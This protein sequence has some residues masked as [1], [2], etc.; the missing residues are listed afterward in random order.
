MNAMI[1]KAIFVL[2]DTIRI[3]HVACAILC[4]ICITQRLLLVSI[5]NSALSVWLTYRL[6]YRLYIYPLLLSPLRKAPG[7]P[8]GHWLFGQTPTLIRQGSDPAFIQREWMK[9]YGDTRGFIRDIGPFGIER[10]LFL[11][12]QAMHKIL[13]TDWVDYPRV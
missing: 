11:S 10:M 8:Y 12:N 13:I 9:R 6:T 5:L 4:E 7:P 2:R 1:D 3:W